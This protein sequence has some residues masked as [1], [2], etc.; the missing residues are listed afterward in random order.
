MNGAQIPGYDALESL[1]HLYY[2]IM[3]IAY[4]GTCSS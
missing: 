2:G 1:H 3:K 4:H